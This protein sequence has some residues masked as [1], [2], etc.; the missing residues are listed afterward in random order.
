[1]LH[2]ARIHLVAQCISQAC[3]N[4]LTL[5]GRTHQMRPDICIYQ[6]KILM[7]LTKCHMNPESAVERPKFRQNRLLVLLSNFHS[8]LQP[9]SRVQPLA[10]EHQAVFCTRSKSIIYKNNLK[11]AVLN[12]LLF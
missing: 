5:H 2:P 12:D 7:K 9:N 8:G 1:M 6:R 11:N 4:V 10:P 3:D